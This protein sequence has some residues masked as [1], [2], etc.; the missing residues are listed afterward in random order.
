MATELKPC[1]FCGGTDIRKI[2]TIFDCDIWC[3]D[4]KASM[5]RENYMK[6]DT[7]RETV[8][9]AEPEAVKAWNRRYEPGEIDFDYEAEDM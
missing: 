6:C 3:A 2:I 8:S 4:C 7:I 1:P 9:D 5:H